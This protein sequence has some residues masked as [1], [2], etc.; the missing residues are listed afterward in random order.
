ME[1]HH[2]EPFRINSPEFDILNKKLERRNFLVKTS[3]G[4]GALAM[5]SL[6]G[7]QKLFGTGATNPVDNKGSLEQAVFS[8]PWPNFL[9]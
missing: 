4:L 6:F 1:N 2:E 5:G 8:W 7:A 9:C 3:L